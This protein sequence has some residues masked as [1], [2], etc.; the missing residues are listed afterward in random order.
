LGQVFKPGAF[1]LGSPTTVLEL[2]AKAGSFTELAKTKKIVIT[3]RQGS[4]QTQLYFNYEDFIEG[5][6]LQ[7]NILLKSGD[8]VI[9]P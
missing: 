1:P 3:R 6:N 4:N 5:K 2:I 8:V 9:V 7:Q